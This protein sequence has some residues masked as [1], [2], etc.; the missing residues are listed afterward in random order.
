MQ[1]SVQQGYLPE[2][3]PINPLYPLPH[4]PQK[5]TFMGNPGDG[6]ESHPTAKKLLISPTRKI[7]LINLILPLSKCYSFPVK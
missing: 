4:P 5:K 2:L 1:N 3:Y 7:P 6:K